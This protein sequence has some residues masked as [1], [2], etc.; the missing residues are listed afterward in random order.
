MFDNSIIALL[1]AEMNDHKLIAPYL[2]G[3]AAAS[4]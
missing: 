4:G 2:L 1:L 3:M